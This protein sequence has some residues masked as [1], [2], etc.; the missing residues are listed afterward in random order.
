MKFFYLF[1]IVYFLA[2]VSAAGQDEPKFVCD[3]NKPQTSAEFKQWIFNVKWIITAGEKET[4]EA[5]E[6]ISDKAAFVDN[7]WMRRDPDPD[8]EENEYRNEFCER[9]AFSDRFASGIPGWLTDRG[10][11]ITLFGE[12]NRIERGSGEFE[13]I[14]TVT[15]EKWHYDHVEGFAGGLDLTFIDPTGTNKFRLTK[16]DSE[17]LAP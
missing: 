3:D 17:K 7:F 8:T 5:L 10:R 4:F 9:I 16:S 2:A 6:P 15:F 12:P 14:D 11:I 1:T 13:H